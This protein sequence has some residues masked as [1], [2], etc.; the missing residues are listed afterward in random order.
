MGVYA[1]IPLVALLFVSHGALVPSWH[2]TPLLFPH[3]AYYI[4]RYLFL[5]SLLLS[6]L[7]AR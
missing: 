3:M 5:P 7:Q 2:L 4:E 1:T 6:Y